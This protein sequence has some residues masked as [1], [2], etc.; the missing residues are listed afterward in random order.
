VAAA[1]GAL[2][3]WGFLQML[4]VITKHGEYL[5]VPSVL[6]K[7]TTESVKLLES[8]GFTVVIQDSVYT[9][10]AKLGTVLKQFPEGNS[11]VKVNRVVM[12][13]VNRITLPLVDMPALIGKSQDYALEILKRAHLI[14]GDTTFKPSYMLG[15]V[16]EQRVN[17][18]AV[19]AG[20]KIPWGS[21]VDLEIGSGLSDEQIIVPSLIGL[22][23]QE[24]KS[25][26]EEKGIM[27]G[28]P[29]VDKGTTDT[30]NAFVYKQNPPRM[31]E[32]MS[33]NYIRSGQIMD[34]WVSPVMKEV[35]DSAANVIDADKLDKEED[36]AKKVISDKKKKKDE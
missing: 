33:T 34:V 2:L 3:I 31:N 5:T 10:T 6:N 18:T 15:A 13:T 23:Y 16:L 12:L 19:T 27:L 20:S 32:D 7:R 22:T 28:N 26:L 8:K 11:T 25:I 29:V 4:G 1:L 21:R 35:V 9:D 17:G 24:A 14:L 30:A 36:K